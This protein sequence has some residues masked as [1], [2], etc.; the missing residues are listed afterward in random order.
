MSLHFAGPG[1]K[2]KGIE[3]IMGEIAHIDFSGG[4]TKFLGFR[5]IFS[6]ALAPKGLDA[7][8]RNLLPR[9]RRLRK[10]AARAE[11]SSWELNAT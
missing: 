10:S 6:A 11:S 8:G 1:V 9:R 7:K 3:S 5:G 4:N 2:K